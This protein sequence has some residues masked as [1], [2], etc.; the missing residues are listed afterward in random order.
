MNISDIE[1][2]IAKSDNAR[3][4]ISEQKNIERPS[5]VPYPSSVAN[6]QTLVGR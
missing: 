6:M 4:L 5:L 2:L 1:S 3:L